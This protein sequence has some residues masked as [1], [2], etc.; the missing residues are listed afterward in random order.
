MVPISRNSRETEHCLFL[1]SH[2]THTLCSTPLQYK[3]F[4]RWAYSLLPVAYIYILPN[5][6]LPFIYFAP[7]PLHHLYLTY[8]KS[9]NT[10]L[11]SPA[12]I[13]SIPSHWPPSLSLHSRQHQFW[14]LFQLPTKCPLLFI[15]LIHKQLA[16]YPS[17]YTLLVFSV[18]FSK[19]LGLFFI[20]LYF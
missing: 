2:P 20:Y 19:P 9:I 12:F 14:Y 11:L 13:S 3:W 8:S 6:P 4:S 10:P 18:L 1:R 15:V 5:K 7:W 17:S 16:R